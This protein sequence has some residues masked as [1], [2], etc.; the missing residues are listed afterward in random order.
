M[1]GKFTVVARLRC[2]PMSLGEGSRGIAAQAAADGAHDHVV[3]DFDDGTRVVY[4]DPRRFGLM[5]LAPAGR[6]GSHRLLRSLG[7]SP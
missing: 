2:S 3:F 7:L 1:T 5:D 6:L 4:A